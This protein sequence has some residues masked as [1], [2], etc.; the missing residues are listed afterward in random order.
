GFMGHRLNF[1]VGLSPIGAYYAICILL[2]NVHT[3]YWGSAMGVRFNCNPPSI[4]E[5]LHF[6]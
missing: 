3:C 1:K 5:Y 4:Y 6:I 2:S